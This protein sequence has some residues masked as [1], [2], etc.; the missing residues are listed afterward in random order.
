MAS[1]MI[2]REV[3]DSGILV[4]ALHPGWVRTDMGTSQAP[5]GP[6]E[7]VEG[8]L[9]VIGN[10]GDESHGKLINFKGEVLPY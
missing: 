7:S 5:V 6:D 2:G 4:A 3:K 10:A 8:M 9:K 1:I